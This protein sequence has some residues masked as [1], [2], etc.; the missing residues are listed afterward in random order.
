MLI[1]LN[2]ATESGKDVIAQHLVEQ[3]G[4]RRIG[5]ADALKQEVAVKFRRTLTVEAERMYG[6]QISSGRCTI[7]EAIHRL[8]WDERTALTRAL[9]QEMGTEVRRADNPSYWTIKWVQAY[10]RREGCSVVV[11]DVRF[12]NEFECLRSWGASFIRLRR[13]GHSV[14]ELA[15][16]HASETSLSEGSFDWDATLDNDGTLDDLR[17]K[18]NQLLPLLKP[19]TQIRYAGR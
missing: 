12:S 17:T 16:D 13:P 4:Y 5:F 3:H 18:T 9:L 14:A 19:A 15:S 7:D 6:H 1:G 11:P 10:L 2:G 8:L